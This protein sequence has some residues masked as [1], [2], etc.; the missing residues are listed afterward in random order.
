MDRLR[1]P[2]ILP[3][4]SAPRLAAPRRRIGLVFGEVDNYIAINREGYRDI[5]HPLAKP[6]GTYRILLLGDSMSE[7]VEVALQDLY[8]KRLESLLPQCAAF[9]NRRIEVVSLAVNGYGT[10]QEYLT[11]REHGLKYRPDLVLLAFFTGNDFTDNVETLGHHRDRPYFMLREGRLVLEQ[12]AGMSGDSPPA[13][14]S[15]I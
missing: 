7:G 13:K 6:P 1:S 10:A 2:A 4:R 15:T 11:L 9:S 5:D 14:A 3:A 8:W 12:T